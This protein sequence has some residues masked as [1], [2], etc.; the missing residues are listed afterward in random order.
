MGVSQHFSCIHYIQ[1]TLML[2]KTIHRL[3]N[4]THLAK[5]N[6][7]YLKLDSIIKIGI[8]SCIITVSIPV[9]NYMTCEIK[10]YYHYLILLL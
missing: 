2:P 7:H 6:L 3:C 4:F 1:I 5:N 9:E 8:F 10:V